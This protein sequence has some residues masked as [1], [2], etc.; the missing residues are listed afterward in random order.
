MSESRRAL[1]AKCFELSSERDSF[2][3]T[4][5]VCVHRGTLPAEDANFR[6]AGSVII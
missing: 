2:L 5:S 6:Q 3:A 1:G 4:G